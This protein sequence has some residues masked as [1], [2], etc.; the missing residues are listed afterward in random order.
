MFLSPIPGLAYSFCLQGNCL[1]FLLRD[2]TL[3]S[4]LVSSIISLPW[5]PNELEGFLA[6][7]S[8]L[9]EMGNVLF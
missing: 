9:S 3:V 4:S 7:L 6:L 2:Q 8:T 5:A 1:Y